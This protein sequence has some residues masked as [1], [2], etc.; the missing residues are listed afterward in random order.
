MAHKDCVCKELKEIAATSSRKPSR[1]LQA[2]LFSLPSSF[3]SAVL[4]ALV[5]PHKE[6]SLI[7]LLPSLWWGKLS[8]S[9]Q[10]SQLLLPRPEEKAQRRGPGLIAHAHV[11]THW[12]RARVATNICGL[13]ICLV[14]LPK[15]SIFF[16]FEQK[17]I[18][19]YKNNCGL[20][21]QKAPVIPA[22]GANH[23]ITSCQ[24]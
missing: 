5:V 4:Q 11:L 12:P 16:F 22:H 15:L 10:F 7:I 19:D 8:F 20:R 13:C 9:A 18:S 3:K 24:T 21:N 17:E 14:S 6:I 2:H 1:R 23:C